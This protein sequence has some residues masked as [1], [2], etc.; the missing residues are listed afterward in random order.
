[1]FVCLF[2]F[3]FLLSL[4]GGEKVLGLGLGLEEEF[5]FSARLVRL[6]ASLELREM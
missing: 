3:D 5:L 4:F 1:M 6:Y 2:A